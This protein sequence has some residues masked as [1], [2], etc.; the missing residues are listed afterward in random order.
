MVSSQKLK[1][2]LVGA[3]CSFFNAFFFK[4]S[5]SFDLPRSTQSSWISRSG[6]SHIVLFK[7]ENT[8][9]HFWSRR[10]SWRECFKAARRINKISPKLS[11]SEFPHANRQA[12]VFLYLAE[13]RSNRKQSFFFSWGRARFIFAIWS[14][15]FGHEGI[16]VDAIGQGVSRP[17]QKS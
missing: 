8:I 14:Y 11:L 17:R 5:A 4:V 9:N 16:G 15:D 10:R 2:F 13:L 12:S 6:M 3:F 1:Q 7:L